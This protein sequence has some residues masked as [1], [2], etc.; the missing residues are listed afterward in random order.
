MFKHKGLLFG[1]V[2][3]SFFLLMAL[4]APWIAPH[5]PSAINGEYY[6]I[7]PMWA[8]EGLKEFLL[9]TDDLG[10]DIFSRLLYGTRISLFIGVCVVFISLTI[11][12]TL[13]LMAGYFQKKIDSF[14]MG[15]T[16][17]L[18]AFPNI[19]LAILVISI[20]GP[21]LSNAIL[22]SAVV[23]IPNFT[24]LVRSQVLMEK[25][26]DYHLAAISTGASHLQGDLS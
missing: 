1:A 17:I 4:L 20:L 15:F 12:T 19:L 16:D 14:I 5:D 10:R 24:R 3:I 18:M 7:P 11:G 21:G 13:G 8:Q 9:G 2:I 26:K 22:A 23:A 6:K 25:N